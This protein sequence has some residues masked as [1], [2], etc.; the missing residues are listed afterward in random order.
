MRRWELIDF[1]VGVSGAF[2]ATFLAAAFAQFI[3]EQPI[4]IWCT[5]ELAKSI[6]RENDPP[7]AE[8]AQCKFTLLAFISGLLLVTYLYRR[9]STDKM[10]YI[11]SE[12]RENLFLHLREK[13][14]K[15]SEYENLHHVLDRAFSRAVKLELYYENI[16][17][18][19]G[20]IFI[21]TSLGLGGYIVSQAKSPVESFAGTVFGLGLY[22]IYIMLFSR[23]AYNVRSF[24]AVAKFAEEAL[25]DPG[26]SRGKLNIPIFTVVYDN[27]RLHKI[28]RV[29]RVIMAGLYLYISLASYFLYQIIIEYN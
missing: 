23:F 3:W 19:T 17:W 7:L 26:V 1:V 9:T 22:V 24:R 18:R 15:R 21:P 2:T 12:I 8:V 29:R 28:Y 10:E 25:N 14:L 4:E 27:K 16:I 6:L 20:E 5:L 13:L 11:E